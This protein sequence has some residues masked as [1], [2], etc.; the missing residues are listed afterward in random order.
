M[1]KVWHFLDSKDRDV[2][3]EWASRLQKRELGKLQ[4]K[5]DSLIIHGS[6]LMPQTLS[7]TGEPNIKKL[8]VHGKVQ[9]RP[10]LC[11]IDSDDGDEQWV[12]LV[13]AIEKG[14]NLDPH[15]ALATAKKRRMELLADETRKTIHVRFKA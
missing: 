12:F 1:A 10:L 2:F 6:G 5:I 9:L 7:D 13:G 15:D 3:K 14:W 4:A 8:K 11:K